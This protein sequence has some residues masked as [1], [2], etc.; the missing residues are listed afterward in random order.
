MP[1]NQKPIIRIIQ[2]PLRQFGQ[3][4][5]PVGRHKLR[6]EL[7]QIQLPHRQPLRNP[8]EV[9]ILGWWLYILLQ[10]LLYILALL[11]LLGSVLSGLTWWL[12]LLLAFFWNW[13]FLRSSGEFLDLFLIVWMVG[14]FLAEERKS[15]ITTLFLFEDVLEGGAIFSYILR[16][17]VDCLAECFWRLDYAGWS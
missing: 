14:V 15:L 16:G 5:I 9:L 11:N 12:I 8:L 6:C 3:K 10:L 1:R 2:L 17:L 7:Y 13:G 4:I